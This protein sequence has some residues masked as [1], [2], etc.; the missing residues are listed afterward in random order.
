MNKLKTVS[1]TPSNGHNQ[2]QA[3]TTPLPVSERKFLRAKG[4][5]DY[6]SISKSHFHALVRDGVLPTGKLISGAV[7]VFDRQA[8]D[9]AAKKMWRAA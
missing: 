4:A 8:L 6:L 5:A 1:D 9:E 7:R 3:T 2:V